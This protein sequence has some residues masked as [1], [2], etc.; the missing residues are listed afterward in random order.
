MSKNKVHKKDYINAIR[1]YMSN[2]PVMERILDRIYVWGDKISRAYFIMGV[3][4][5]GGVLF[6]LYIGLPEEITKWLSPVIGVTFSVVIA[7]I[8]LSMYGRKKDVVTKRFESNYELYEEVLDVLV[9]MVVDRGHLEL[10]I[11]KYERIIQ[12]NFAQ[13]YLRFGAT[14]QYS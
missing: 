2:H 11:D 5:L 12:S 1:K 4:V 6:L 13:M 3:L 14:R 8:I 10:Y 9:M 7:P